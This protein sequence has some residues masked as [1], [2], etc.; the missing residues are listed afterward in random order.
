V[1]VDVQGWLE[2]YRR[3]WEEADP[4]ALVELFEETATYRSHIF[5]EPPIGLEAIRDYWRRATDTQEDVHVTFGRP[6]RDGDRV[7]VEWWTTLRDEGE[8]ITLPGCLLLRFGADG[9]CRMLREYWHVEK[10][11]HEPPP[12]WG[13]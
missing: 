10:G 11:R 8:E 6:V 3:A 9:R 5:R 7:A 4:D 2:R 13:D 12:D 1:T